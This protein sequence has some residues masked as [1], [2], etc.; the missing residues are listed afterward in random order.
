MGWEDEEERGEEY[1]ETYEVDVVGVKM[2][3][4]VLKAPKHIKGLHLGPTFA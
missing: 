3:R 1:E 2:D 4:N